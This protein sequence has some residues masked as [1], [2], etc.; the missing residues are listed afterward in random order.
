MRTKMTYISTLLAAGAAAVAIIAPPTAVATPLPKICL[1]TDAGTACHS[2]G[3]ADITNFVP[4]VTAHL[5]AN[6]A[7]LR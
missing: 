7:A 4:P 1:G 3:A 6:K 5:F 2:P